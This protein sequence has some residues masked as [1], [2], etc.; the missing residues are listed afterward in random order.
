MS[1]KII[2][3]Y[4]LVL[5]VGITIIVIGADDLKILNKDKENRLL[6]EYEKMQM[7]SKERTA[8]KLKLFGIFIVAATAVSFLGNL[9]KS[10]GVF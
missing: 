3:L 7:R 6:S 10:F 4:I 8:A 1:I 2:L 5:V 9:L